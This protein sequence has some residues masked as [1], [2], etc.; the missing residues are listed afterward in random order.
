MHPEPDCWRLFS[1]LYTDETKGIM[2]F[3]RILCGCAI[4]LA[5]HT[6]NGQ[7]YV[8]QAAVAPLL[9]SQTGSAETITP[10]GWHRYP[11]SKTRGGQKQVLAALQAHLDS[12]PGTRTTQRLAI[13]ELSNRVSARY[14]MQRAELLIPDEFPD[15]FRAYAPYPLQWTGAAETDKVFVVDKYTQTF[16]AYEYG[17]LVRWGLVCTGREDG[18]TPTGRFHFNWKQEYRESTEAPPGEVWKMRWVYNFHAPAGIHVHQY[19]LPM[20]TPASHGC[21]R[22]SESDAQWNYNWASGWKDL[23]TP[24]ATPGTTI[25]VLNYN[26]AGM[27]AHWADAGVPLVMLPES[28]A[29][30]PEG[31]VRSD[32]VA[33]R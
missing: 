24:G 25:L 13:V 30:V 28:P 12:L 6:T 16:A 2:T 21:V 15:D 31:P 18:L 10:V 29:D 1:L 17:A 8:D 7:G 32:G 22:L 33:Q 26:P 23:K 11:I 27:A 14:V 9:E 4:L 5:S 3:R 20:A 19:Q